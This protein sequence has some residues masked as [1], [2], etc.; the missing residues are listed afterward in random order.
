[1][2]VVAFLW[3]VSPDAQLVH[4]EA[5]M[6]GTRRCHRRRPVL[7]MTFG[8]TTRIARVHHLSCRRKARDLWILSTVGARRC[9]CLTV[10]TRTQHGPS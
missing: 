1:L 6:R 8:T 4:P 9:L 3:Q 10:A 7:A 5:L 2:E